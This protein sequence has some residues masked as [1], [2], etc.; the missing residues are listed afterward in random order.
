MF[1]MADMSLSDSDG[2]SGWCLL[3][4]IQRHNLSCA[5]H[6]GCRDE[7]ARLCAVR[8]CAALH[9]CVAPCG[10]EGA[11]ESV[12]FDLGLNAGFTA[13]EIGTGSRWL[14]RVYWMDGVNCVSGLGVA[15]DGPD[16]ML[17]SS[18]DAN[19]WESRTAGEDSPGRIVS[20]VVLAG[21]ITCVNGDAGVGGSPVDPPE[22]VVD[23]CSPA[24]S[25]PPPFDHT[26]IVPQNANVSTST[27]VCYQR[28][29]E[30]FKGDRLCPCYVSPLRFPAGLQRPRVPHIANDN[31]DS[32]VAG[33]QES[34]KVE[35]IDGSWDRARWWWVRESRFSPRGV[36]AAGRWRVSQ[37][38]AVV[39]KLGQCEFESREVC[40]PFRYNE[41]CMQ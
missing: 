11:C 26:D 12:V 4:G 20:G 39:A 6:G 29:D 2:V 40:P 17:H 28:T 34:W 22:D 38:P 21:H 18:W 31:G 13:L 16:E 15:C 41:R 10:L 35:Y 23:Q 8:G 36:L 30:E 9:A 32:R 33:V 24:P 14:S 37:H 19:G 5:G 3:T 7:G 1:V 27:R 25:I